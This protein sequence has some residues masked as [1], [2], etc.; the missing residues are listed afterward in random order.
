MGPLLFFG[1][2]SV[3]LWAILGRKRPAVGLPGA[4][5]GGTPAGGSVV[6]PQALAANAQMLFRDYQWTVQVPSLTDVSNFLSPPPG[7]TIG[8]GRWWRMPGGLSTGPWGPPAVGHLA[9][10][11]AQPPAV[12]LPSGPVAP[13]KIVQVP[14]WGGV[15]PSSAIY[16]WRPNTG[17]SQALNGY[18][19]YGTSA[20][21]VGLADTLGS[22]SSDALV[23]GKGSTG[24]GFQ[25]YIQNHDLPPPPN[26]VAGTPA[27]SVVSN[28]GAGAKWTLKHPG[29]LVW[30]GA[31]NANEAD[32]AVLS[33]P[34]SV[35]PAQTPS[36]A[37][38]SLA[39]PQAASPLPLVARPSAQNAP[40]QVVH[41]SKVL[42]PPP[43]PTTT[44][45]SPAGSGSVPSITGG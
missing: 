30:L 25:L 21:Y 9:R 20:W 17:T 11:G 34:V 12:G 35:L 24:S 36:G 32:L 2:G 22:T 7:A 6:T 5:A 27:A 29:L 37:V 39:S 10:S 23:R 45:S 3:A 4:P 19:F 44:L 28:A 33:A 16:A 13:R 38:P 42:P 40:P 18:L 15:P 14:T 8:S 31:S 1:V 43:K 26:P 41:A